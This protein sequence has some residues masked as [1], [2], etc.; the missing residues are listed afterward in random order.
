[1]LKVAAFRRQS[2]VSEELFI[3]SWKICEDFSFRVLSQKKV[4]QFT[5]ERLANQ[6][7]AVEDS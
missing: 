5:S 6:L 4:Q 1:M 2:S 7:T 3:D